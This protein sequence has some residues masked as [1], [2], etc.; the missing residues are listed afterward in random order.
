MDKTLAN[1]F[2]GR[3]LLVADGSTSSDNAA[4]FAF[5]LAAKTGATVVAGYPIDT[6]TMDYLLQMHIFVEDE[7]EDFEEELVRK[8]NSYLARMMEMGEKFH[9]KTECVMCKGRFHLSL[10]E[11]AHKHHCGMIVLGAWRTSS[12][13]HDTFSHER[14]L[15]VQFADC[16]VTVVK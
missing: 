6:A 8:G 13:R 7:R 2:L 3:I 11:A 15:F 12:Q 1:D 5:G 4:R 10:L 9:V 14:E 16:P